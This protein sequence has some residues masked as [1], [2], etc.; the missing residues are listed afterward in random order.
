[1]TKNHI[2]KDSEQTKIYLFLVINFS[3]AYKNSLNYRRIFSHRFLLVYC[4][5]D[6]SLLFH[7]GTVQVGGGFIT[8]SGTLF[9]CSSCYSNIYARLYQPGKIECN[10][11]HNE[12]LHF[13]RENLQK[14]K[15]SPFFL[16]ADL[17]LSLTAKVIYD[18][19]FLKE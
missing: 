4:S 2:F 13:L 14:L 15:C 1:M 10:Q 5:R 6:V 18:L 19:A 9:S 8:Y 3:K 11:V 7:P 17:T 12:I 16:H